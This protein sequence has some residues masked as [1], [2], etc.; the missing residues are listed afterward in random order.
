MPDMAQSPISPPVNLDKVEGN[1]ELGSLTEATLK[2]EMPAARQARENREAADAAHARL[3]ALLTL[4]MAGFLLLGFFGLGV[5]LFAFKI[6][7]TE[8]QKLYASTVLTAIASGSAGYAFGK[9]N[10]KEKE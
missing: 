2:Q 5:Y 3:I 1:I 9:K 10:V 6:D 7:V 4:A 8:A